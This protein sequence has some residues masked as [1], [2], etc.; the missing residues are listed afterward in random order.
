MGFCTSKSISKESAWQ[1]SDFA[2]FC[3][4]EAVLRNTLSLPLPPSYILSLLSLRE[5]ARRSSSSTAV[6]SLVFSVYWR[7]QWKGKEKVV[8]CSYLFLFFSFFL[9]QTFCLLSFSSTFCIAFDI[10]LTNARLSYPLYRENFAF[11]TNGYP[12]AQLHYVYSR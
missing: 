8:S 1:K 3:D 6:A 5:G 9:I 10:A 2:S 7:I 4:K 11:K 12:F